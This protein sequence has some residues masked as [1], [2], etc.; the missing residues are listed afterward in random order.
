MTYN[1]TSLFVIFTDFRHEEWSVL[2]LLGSKRV[3]LG[4]RIEIL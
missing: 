2:W 3:H 1:R 4:K